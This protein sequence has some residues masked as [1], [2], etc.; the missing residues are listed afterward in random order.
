[1]A[2]KKE[3]ERGSNQL[4]TIIEEKIK[5]AMDLELTH[6]PV[7]SGLAVEQREKKIKSWERGGDNDVSWGKK[8]D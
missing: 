4:T 2:S 5:S 8:G 3:F 7:T 6:Y 1:L